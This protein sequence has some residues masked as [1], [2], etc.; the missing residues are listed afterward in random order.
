MMENLY[1]EKKTEN[2]PQIRFGEFTDD[3]EIHEIGEFVNVRKVVATS[4]LPL[5]SLTIEH[6]VVPKSKRYER[7]FLV[8]GG[9]EGAYKLMHPN[10]FTFNPMNLRFGALAKYKGQLNVAIS[11]YYDIFYCKENCNPEYLELF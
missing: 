1:K 10:D 7:S 6:G 8:K 5:F 9:E 2:V 4:D 3:W 11:K